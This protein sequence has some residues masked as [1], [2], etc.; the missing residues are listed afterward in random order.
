MNNAL[1]IVRDIRIV[2]DHYQGNVV[3]GMQSTQD[4]HDF[5]AGFAVQISG[6]LI[7]QD[8]RRIF[9]QSPGDSYSLLFASGKLARPVLD[10]VSQTDSGQGL[11]GCLR[12]NLAGIFLSQFYIV[13][14]R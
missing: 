7:G 6:R 12:V 4:R 13:D 2:C 10:T 9:S 14:S 11:P 5:F 8:D 3:F 1:A